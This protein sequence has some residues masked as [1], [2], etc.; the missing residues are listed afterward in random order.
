[1]CNI[2]YPKFPCRTCAKSVSDKA[3]QCDLYE[4]FSVTSA[5]L[6]IQITGIFK[7]AT[8][9]GIAWNVATQYFLLT[10]YL[11]TNWLLV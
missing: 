2:N 6:I 3:V 5:I 9:S 1:M 10:P 11:V 4:L 8:N 7:T